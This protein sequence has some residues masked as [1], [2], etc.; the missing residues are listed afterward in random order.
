MTIK[1]R[2]FSLALYLPIIHCNLS[3]YTLSV[4]KKIVNFVILNLRNFEKHLKFINSEHIIKHE[5]KLTCN[6]TL[7]VL[8][9]DSLSKVEVEQKNNHYIFIDV[10]FST[11]A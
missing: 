5:N 3:V 4:Y 2:Y 7:K 11:C 8:E 9:R 10:I 6:T 1:D